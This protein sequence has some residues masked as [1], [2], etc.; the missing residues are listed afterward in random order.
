[1]LRTIKK[2]FGA[3]SLLLLTLSIG[4]GQ[5]DLSRLEQ[6]IRLAQERLKVLQT[7]N[8]NL[9]L[10]SDSL[11]IFINTLKT[12]PTMGFLERR[13]LERLLRDS[14]DLASAREHNL[15]EQK[16]QKNHLEQIVATLLKRYDA[17]IDS[18]VQVAERSGDVSRVE[19]ASRI[20]TL[21]AR[22]SSVNAQSANPGQSLQRPELALQPNDLPED[23]EVK[24]EFLRD[25]ADR[26]RQQERTLERRIKD[27][28]AEKTLRKKMNDLVTDVR[29]FDQQDEAIRAGTMTTPTSERPAYGDKAGSTFSDPAPGHAMTTPADYLLRVDIRALS[30]QD[31]DAYIRELEAERKRLS[32]RADS[33]IDNARQFDL[34]AQK[35]RQSFEEKR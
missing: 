26:L 23:I 14:Q 28:R 32:S 9:Q 17:V 10:Q 18:L 22:R 5:A 30:E 6:G 2:L 35:Q 15:H 20:Q 21:R 11:A 1:M 27:V 19:T 34:E 29:L 25:R 4:Y 3:F 12:A 7:E 24:A 13:K 31:T 33:L 16:Q 8:Q